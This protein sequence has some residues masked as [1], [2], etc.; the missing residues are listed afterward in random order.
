MLQLTQLQQQQ[1]NKL[2][3]ALK[4]IFVS[5]PRKHGKVYLSNLIKNGSNTT[6]N[7]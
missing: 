2:V 7:K 5:F 3:N 6:S 1:A 4:H